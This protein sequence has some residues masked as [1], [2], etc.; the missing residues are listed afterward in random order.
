MSR[1]TTAWMN[2]YYRNLFGE[3]LVPIIAIY[4]EV[5]LG[6]GADDAFEW[7]AMMEIYFFLDSHK[8]SDFSNI[9]SLAEQYQDS[10]FVP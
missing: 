3:R 6:E 8:V 10:D 2:D 7:E 4:D 1:N 9:K 5:Y